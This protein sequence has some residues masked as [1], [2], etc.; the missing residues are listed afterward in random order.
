MREELAALEALVAELLAGVQEMLQ[1]GERLSDEFQGA[2]AD[3]LEWVTTRIMELQNEIQQSPAEGLA[4]PSGPPGPLTPGPFPS[5]NVNSFLYDPKSEN[6]FVKFHGAN[7]ADAGPTYEYGGVPRYIYDIFSKGA[8]GPKTSGQNRYH[9]W[10]KG[11]TPSLG[12][13]LNALI[14]AGN[15]PYR[16]M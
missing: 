13:S 16:R 14:K 3:E 12:G 4:P 7:S 6:L 15:F 1:S 8:I 2:I 10:I 11:V 9:K 5:S